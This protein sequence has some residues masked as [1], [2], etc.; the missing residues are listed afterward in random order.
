[1]YTQDPTQS[2]S[3]QTIK[4]AFSNTPQLKSVRRSTFRHKMD[5][6]CFFFFF[7]QVVRSKRYTLWGPA[8]PPNPGFGPAKKCTQ[9]QVHKGIKSRLVAIHPHP[10]KKKGPHCTTKWVTYV[11]F[12]K[13]WGS[14]GIFFGVP[15]PL[16]IMTLGL[17]NNAPY[18]LEWWHFVFVYSVNEWDLGY[19]LS[20]TS[21]TVLK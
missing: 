7:L 12:Y 16:E 13:W 4:Q 3:V 10:R 18:I 5:Q 17:Q 19:T 21:K 11:F 15:H 20:F 1:M 2:S 14:K 9:Y 8:P 6:K